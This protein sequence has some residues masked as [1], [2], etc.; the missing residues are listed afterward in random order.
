MLSGIVVTNGIVLVDKIERNLASG[1]DPQKAI[2][3]GTASRVRPVLMT[4]VTTILTLLPLSFS[5]SGD[6]I[7]SQTLGIV[8]VCGMI[9]ST[10]ISLLLIPVIYEFLHRKQYVLHIKT[11]T[12]GYLQR[13]PDGR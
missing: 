11:K 7:I 12:I 8:V 9:S 2:L 13:N 4:A 1:M 5:S 3:Q 6:T 10:M